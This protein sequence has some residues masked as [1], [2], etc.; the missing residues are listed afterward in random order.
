MVD[1]D[2]ALHL[3]ADTGLPPEEIDPEVSAGDD[4]ATHLSK[5]TGVDKA[6]LKSSEPDVVGQGLAAQPLD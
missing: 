4:R 2:T 5:D 1:R 3:A 6:E